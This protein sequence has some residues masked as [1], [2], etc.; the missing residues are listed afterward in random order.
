M[1]KDIAGKS[2]TPFTYPVN[3]YFPVDLEESMSTKSSSIELVS[4]V[5]SE[6]DHIK[7]PKSPKPDLMTESQRDV[8]QGAMFDM[9]QRP[10]DLVPNKVES[11]PAASPIS[12][13][14]SH[15]AALFS[16]QS[17][18]QH[19]SLTSTTPTLPNRS[20][21][22]SPPTMPTRSSAMTPP[23]MPSRSS[24]STPPAMPG[25]STAPASL[26]PSLPGR[27]AAVP[28]PKSGLT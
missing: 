14:T 22:T 18:E 28:S 19:M 27:V 8:N 13:S 24:G 11:S 16:Q 6:L 9:M 10:T 1:K 12:V 2:Y 15:D 26:P 4:P 20:G 7:T 5:I 21:T 17:P 3:P 23:V 25:R